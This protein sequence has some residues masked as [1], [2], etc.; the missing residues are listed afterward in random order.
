M[1]TD[2]DHSEAGSNEPEEIAHQPRKHIL[3]TGTHL[4][5]IRGIAYRVEACYFSGIRSNN[6]PQWAVLVARDDVAT[7]EGVH[8]EGASLFTTQEGGLF[9]VIMQTITQ[10]NVAVI[11]PSAEE[12]STVCAVRSSGE[13]IPM[14][15]VKHVAKVPMLGGEI[16]LVHVPYEK[17]SHLLPPDC[18]QGLPPLP[19]S[20]NCM[21]VMQRVGIIGDKKATDTKYRT[22]SPWVHCKFTLDGA[23]VLHGV[24]IPGGSRLTAHISEDKP[25][26]VTYTPTGVGETTF[27]GTCTMPMSWGKGVMMHSTPK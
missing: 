23:V 5:R 10:G 27:S 11:W 14:H 20:I 1:I 25:V 16:R 18:E 26:G 9:S 12:F 7:G 22:P 4:L 13:K 8:P 24:T 21:C 19:V 2:Q 6:T 15:M 3:A 17:M